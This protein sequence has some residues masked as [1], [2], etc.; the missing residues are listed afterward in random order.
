MFLA[1]NE[2]KKEKLR[3][4]LIIAVI[5]MIAY[6]IFILSSLALGLSNENTTA[7][8]SWQVQSVAMSKDAD[9]NL[10]QSMLT[11]QDYQ[12][13]KQ[14]NNDAVALA[15]GILKNDSSREA[16]T[17]IGIDAVSR[18]DRKI[19]ITQGRNWKTSNEVVLSNKLADKGFKLGQ[20]VKMGMGSQNYTVVGFAKNAEYNM[21]PVVYGDRSQ[22]NSIKG[23]NS[24]FV[25]SGLVAKQTI[26]TKDS[27]LQVL[28]LS[29]LFDKMP[30]YSAQNST[31]TFMI[32]FLVIIS[33]VIV[34]IF[35]YILT[36]QKLQNFAVLRAQG[37][38][39]R[40]LIQNTLAETILI[41]LIAVITSMVLALLTSLVIPSAVPMYFDFNLIGLTGLGV[42]VMGILGAIIPIRII[43]KID[44]VT[45]IGG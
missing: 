42:T 14:S 35:L 26:H 45:V 30:G 32:A 12:Q 44:P 40:Y 21:A 33:V 28:N 3:Y 17:F 43:A 10:T 37:V 6:L 22:W 27:N 11:S 24:N 29:Q 39:S 31:F 15:Q 16:A 36:V 8:K 7:V 5:M 4:G 1:I 9:G 25:A 41:M 38:P 34:A 18:I 13:A 19:Q 23:V 20:T 2:I